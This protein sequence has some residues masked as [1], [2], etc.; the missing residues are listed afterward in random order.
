[1]ALTTGHVGINVTQLDRSRAF[2]QQVF[3]FE[4]IAEGK[5]P[6]HEFVFLGHGGQIVVTLWPQSE[7]R[8]SGQV[9]GLHHLSFQVDTLEEV[10]RAEATLRE[11]GAEFAYDGVVPHSEGAASG[12]IFFTDPD[13]IRLEIYTPSGVKGEAPTPSAPTCG[14]F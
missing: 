6:G 13:G 7:G 3:G 10:L 11:L 8:F 4:V 5:D 12:G 1:M 2:Y 14:F 9:P